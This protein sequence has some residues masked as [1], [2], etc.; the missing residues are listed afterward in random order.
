MEKTNKTYETKIDYGIP[1]AILV[2]LKYGDKSA[3]S[4]ERSLNELSALT[5]AC[6]LDPVITITQTLAHPDGGTFIGSGKV[7]ELSNLIEMLDA[8]I[9]IFGD[10]LSPIQLRNL[11]RILD[12]EVIDRTGLILQIFASRART[13]E[14]R[15]QVEYAQLQFSSEFS[16]SVLYSSS[17]KFKFFLTGTLVGETSASTSLSA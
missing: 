17:V 12:T 16:T 8:D 5:I 6:D 10:S 13:R 15:L 11:E 2:G 4:F 1:K 3:D 9:V 14:S 7:D